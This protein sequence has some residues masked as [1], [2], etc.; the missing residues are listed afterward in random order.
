MEDLFMASSRSND[1]VLTL[2]AEVVS[3]YV[4]HNAIPMADVPALIRL[5]QGTFRAIGEGT[6]ANQPA[7]PSMAPTPPVPV[8]KTV[9]RDYII[10]LEDGRPYRSLRRHL[11]TRGLT[12]E[13]YRRKWGLPANYPM[14]APSF[15]AQRSEIAQR[16][17]LGRTDRAAVAKA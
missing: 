3:A 7:V 17:G 4:G 12:P 13:Q 16:I 15:S 8:N 5:V 9:T 6:A 14:V 10:S 1:R 11:G 2:A